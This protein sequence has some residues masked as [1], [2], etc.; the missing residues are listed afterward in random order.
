LR[1]DDELYYVAA[2]QVI[3]QAPLPAGRDAGFTVLVNVDQDATG[4]L[5][6]TMDHFSRLALL[7]ARCA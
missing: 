7:P 2:L 1:D 5:W 4:A 6:E 3:V